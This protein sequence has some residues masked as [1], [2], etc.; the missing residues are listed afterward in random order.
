MVQFSVVNTKTVFSRSCCLR[1]PV[2]LVF[3]LFECTYSAKAV[4]ISLS[5]VKFHGNTRTVHNET[6]MNEIRPSL[7]RHIDTF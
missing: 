3:W 4:T 1:G 5:N 7:S 6:K 2:P